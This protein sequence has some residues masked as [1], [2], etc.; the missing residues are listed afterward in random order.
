MNSNQFNMTNTIKVKNNINAYETVDFKK[1]NAFNGSIQTRISNYTHE[2]SPNILLMTEKSSDRRVYSI[3]GKN[4]KQIKKA[5][6]T[7]EGNISIEN[8]SGLTEIIPN[9]QYEFT[10]TSGINF[11]RR[12]NISGLSK[13][14]TGMLK[15]N[16]V[17]D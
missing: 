15:I 16:L 11:D 5:I 4:I 10:F 7:L 12:I 13:G 1:D 3:Y 14:E 17:V 2:G 8:K 9:K 6:L